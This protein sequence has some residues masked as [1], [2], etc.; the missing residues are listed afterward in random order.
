MGLFDA[1]GKALGVSGG[2]VFGGVLGGIGGLGKQ[3]ADKASSARQ[4]AFQER[5]SNTAHQRQMADL[6]KAGINPMLSA[7]LGGAS[8]PSGSQYQATNIGAEAVKGGLAGAQAATAKQQ[9]IIGAQAAKAAQYFGMP[10][11]HVP[12]YLKQGYAAINTGKKLSNSAGFAFDK[13]TGSRDPNKGNKSAKQ[14]RAKTTRWTKQGIEDLKGISKAAADK[15][16]IPWRKWS[17]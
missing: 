5:M 13:P 17:N 12:G 8:S 3:A 11:E 6:K 2:D 15:M 1:V 14:S 9:A 16:G 4:M 7:K 10:L